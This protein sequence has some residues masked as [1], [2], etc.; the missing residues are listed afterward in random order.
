MSNFPLL[1]TGA[2]TQY[3][4]AISSS[5]PVAI[6]RFLDASDQRWRLQ[7]KALRSWSIRLALLTDAELWAIEEF[8]ESQLG[9]YTVFT[10]TDPYTGQA[11]P[12]CRVSDPTLTTQYNGPNNGTT[13]LWI[14]E[15][16]G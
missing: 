12:N 6:V 14:V 1:Q 13:T 15:T 8:F 7:A 16:N 10:F 3:P 9:Q 5:Q 4:G 2:V 11:V